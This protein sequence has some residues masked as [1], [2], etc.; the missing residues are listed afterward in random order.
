MATFDS[1]DLRCQ[2]ALP[3][4]FVAPASARRDVLMCFQ[5]HFGSDLT[6]VEAATKKHE[7]IET[8]VKAYGERV[9]AIVAVSDELQR[10][11]YH[12]IK[13]IISRLVKAG[14]SCLCMYYE[15]DIM[16]FQQRQCLATV[17]ISARVIG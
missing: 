2:S 6:G 1:H 5:D 14:V 16:M 15:I 3:I 8:D 12:D 11:D 7:A 13:R 17:G 10:E 4:S 9:Q